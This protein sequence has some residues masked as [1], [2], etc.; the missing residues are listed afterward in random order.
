MLKSTHINPAL[1]TPAKLKAIMWPLKA[2]MGNTRFFAFLDPIHLPE[3]F[4]F[5]QN[6]AGYLKDDDQ[7]LE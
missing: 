4:Y 3:N 5:Y 6:R 7:L 2:K 1:A